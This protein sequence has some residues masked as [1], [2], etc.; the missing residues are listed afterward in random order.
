M[1]TELVW[2]K[3]DCRWRDHAALNAAAA[4]GRVRCIYVI[5]PSIW[6]HKRL[7]INLPLPEIL[8]LLHGVRH[9]KLNGKNLHSSVLCEL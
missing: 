2:F 1:S 7:A 4:R 6:Q 8:P 9:I 3:R 5:E